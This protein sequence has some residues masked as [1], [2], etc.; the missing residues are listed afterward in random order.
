MDKFVT[1]YDYNET[2]GA[3][4]YCVTG[5]EE[6]C[7]RTTCHKSKTANSCK[8]GT[9]ILYKVNNITVMPFHVMFDQGSKLI[10]QGQKSIVTDTERCSKEGHKEATGSE[11][12]YSKNAIKLEPIT[13]RCLYRV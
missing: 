5:K 9:I 4:Y 13:A 10:M 12:D 7:K 6:T 8:A 2:E 11:D 3:S 1:V